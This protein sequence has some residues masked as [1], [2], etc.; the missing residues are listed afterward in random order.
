MA[1]LFPPRQAAERCTDCR[2]VVRENT[3]AFRSDDAPRHTDQLFDA[4]SAVTIF[5]HIDA[6]HFALIAKHKF[7]DSLG[8]F[9]FT[10]TG[11]AEKE[12]YAI[13]T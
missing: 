8:K 7:G 6:D 9:G 2:G 3:A 4:D 1:T 5:A 11:R 13:R 10:H 12:Q